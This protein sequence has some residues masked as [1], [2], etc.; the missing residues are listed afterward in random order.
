MSIFCHSRSARRINSA[1]RYKSRERVGGAVVLRAENDA[2]HNL[3]DRFR[4]GVRELLDGR[5]AL[6]H[7]RP[8]IEQRGA[9]AE[10]R[11]VER[12]DPG[13]ERLGALERRIDRAR[14]YLH[15]RRSRC[16]QPE[17]RCAAARGRMRQW[18][19]GARERI[20]VVVG[21]GN[22]V[23][24]PGIARGQREDRDGIERTARRH[25]ARCAQRALRRLQADEIVERGRYAARARR[26]G[27][28]R[29]RHETC[30]DGH[31][32]T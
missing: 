16:L 14:A 23:H 32:R 8:L 21:G 13:A 17:C 28:E 25:D 5:V 15:R 29:K 12:H 19:T 6:R 27:A 1:S 10:W 7:P 24:A 2:A 22:I 26:I 4:R 3:M 31:R 20:G 9:F 18:R 11:E 30:R